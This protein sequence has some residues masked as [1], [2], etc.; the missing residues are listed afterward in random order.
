MEL[1]NK[2][3]ERLPEEL[4]ADHPIYESARRR[5]AEATE[6]YE[7]TKAEFMRAAR[8]IESLERSIPRLKNEQAELNARLKD[9]ALQDIQANDPKFT[10]AIGARAELQRMTWEIEARTDAIAAANRTRTMHATAEGAASA[11]TEAEERFDSLRS[12]LFRALAG[13]AETGTRYEVLED[14]PSRD[15][16]IEFARTLL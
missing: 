12:R 2:L 10:R 13:A 5:L 8:I 16:A 9:L 7:R 14:W 11:H 6:R 15:Q 4:L 1:A 3:A